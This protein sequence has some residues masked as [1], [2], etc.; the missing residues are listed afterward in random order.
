MPNA[1]EEDVLYIHPVTVARGLNQWE[2]AAGELA[3]RWPAI[4][5][6]L[7]ALNAA[8]PWG[9]GSEGLRFYS[10]YFE[11]N[12]PNTMLE[13]GDKVVDEL[14]KSGPAMRATISNSMSTDHGEVERIKRLIQ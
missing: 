14:V 4:E 1:P 9:S 6:R 8:R 11:S 10:R 2:T 12:G 7:R 5:A 13:K 3:E